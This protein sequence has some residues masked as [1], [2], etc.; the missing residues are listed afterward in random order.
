MKYKKLTIMET[1]KINFFVATITPN[2]ED[3]VEHHVELLPFQGYT[4]RFVS[5]SFDETNKL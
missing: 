3:P 5:S 4:S 1:L 2:E